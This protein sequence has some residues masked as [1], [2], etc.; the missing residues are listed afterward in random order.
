MVF[1]VDER[2]GSIGIGWNIFRHDANVALVC[3]NTGMLVCGVSVQ[4]EVNVVVGSFAVTFYVRV[5]S[6]DARDF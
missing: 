2:I 5:S 3:A 4:V 6:K 1:H